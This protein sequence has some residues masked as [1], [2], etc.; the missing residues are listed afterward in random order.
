MVTLTDNSQLFA[1]YSIFEHRSLQLS[2][3]DFDRILTNNHSEFADIVKL[4]IFK[5]LSTMLNKHI[6][7][8][9]ILTHS[10]SILDTSETVF[11]PFRL[12]IFKDL[13]TILNK[14]IDRIIILT[15]SKSTL[16][17]SE[18]VLRP[19][20]GERNNVLRLLGWNLLAH[21]LARR[22]LAQL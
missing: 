16:D 10:K 12:S 4:F 19:F 22:N 1:A 8:I 13:S 14:H 17:T 15:H 21:N 2:R 20:G 11:R 6:D 3:L 7:R 5:D 18:T 9:I